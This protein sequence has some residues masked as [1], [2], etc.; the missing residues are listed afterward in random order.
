MRPTTITLA[1]NGRQRWRRVS[2]FIMFVAFPVTMYYLSPVLSLFGATDRIVTGSV[3]VFGFQFITS[4][5]F[6]RAFCGWLCPAGAAHEF[7]LPIQNR[8]VPRWIGWIKFGIWVPWLGFILYSLIRPGDP[9]EVDILAYTTGGISIV[10]LQGYIV[11]YMVLTAFVGLG[12]A[13]GR[14]AGCHTLCW[15]APFMIVGRWLRNLGKWPAL[16]LR[17]NRGDCISCG[18]CSTAC[19]MS[20]NVQELV[21]RERME[22]RDCILCG[23]CV[24]TCPNGVIRYSVSAGVQA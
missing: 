14:R 20:I 23:N 6:G 7:T 13:V 22:D 1:Y 17:A 3:V 10:D 19:P 8:P 5:F 9:L 16:R 2:L 12:L 18:K 11:Y 24:D 21:D 15:M 4:L